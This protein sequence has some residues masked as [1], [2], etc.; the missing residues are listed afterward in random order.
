VIIAS[1]NKDITQTTG[2]V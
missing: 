1:L 2:L